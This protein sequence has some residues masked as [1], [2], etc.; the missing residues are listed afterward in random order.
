MDRY[1]RL[2]HKAS[3]TFDSVTKSELTQV[4]AVVGATVY[5]IA[6]GKERVAPRLLPS[7]V[8]SEFKAA[9]SLD[10]YLYL[11]AHALLP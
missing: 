4:T 11:K 2:H 6:D 9:D 1:G 5:A 7:G 10:A 3:D 8:Q